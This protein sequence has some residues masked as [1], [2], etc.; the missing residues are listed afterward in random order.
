MTNSAV[1]SE[2]DARPR[3]VACQVVKSGCADIFLRGA[4]IRGN[5]SMSTF[6]QQSSDGPDIGAFNIR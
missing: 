3:Y 4:Y 5:P 6:N 1:T 2:T